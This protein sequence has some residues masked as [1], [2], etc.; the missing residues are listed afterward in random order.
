MND[1]SQL[2][3]WL[4]PHAIAVALCAARLLPIAFL[5]P[6]LGGQA[7]PMTVRLGVTLALS[8][9]IHVAGGV[10]PTGVETAWGLVGAALK[11]VT[12]GMVIGLLASLPFDAA[13]TGGRFID[14][15]RGSSAEAAL[16]SARTKESATGDALYQLLVTLVITG[17][18]FPLVLGSIVR[19]FKWIPLGAFNPSE[20]LAL[21]V[22]RLVGVA[23]A[24]GLAIGGPIA[25]GCL[26]VDWFLGLMSRGA[27]NLQLSELSAPLRIL[28]GGAA[29]WLGVGVIA[30][31]LLHTVA[32]QQDAIASLLGATQ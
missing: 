7:A 31:R 12:F 1:W 29:L 30:E 9:G 18:M 22:A 17:G 25:A 8:L 20:H 14:L 24:T 2:T 13:R 3:A 16:P 27:P 32:S 6:L 28:G 5:C 4:E 26:L 23:F 10:A 19:S 21:E 11:E 15:F